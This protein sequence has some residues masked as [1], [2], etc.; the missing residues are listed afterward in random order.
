MPKKKKLIRKA[1]KKVAR[2]AKKTRAKAPA[3]KKK[4]VKGRSRTG[5]KVAVEFMEVDVTTGI[6]EESENGNGSAAID[7][8]DEHYPPDYGG[9]E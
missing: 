7:P 8:M 9:S 2:P 4:S 3:R 1:K 6:E 5:G